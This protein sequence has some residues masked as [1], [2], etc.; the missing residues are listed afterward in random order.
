[1]S[2]DH[3][4]GLKV[5][6][7]LRHTLK[8]ACCGNACRHCVWE[9][10]A[11]SREVR[12]RRRFNSAF[13]VDKKDLLVVEETVEREAVKEEVSEEGPKAAPELPTTCC[14]SGCANCVWL[15]YGQELVE[16]YQA[17]GEVVGLDQLLEVV[18][19][20]V[21]DP[22]VRAFVVMELKAKFRKL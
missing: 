7:R 17:R 5:I 3:F 12:D 2:S 11:V 13:W 6:T 15:D 22:M 19:G 4:P 16:Y 1:M 21:Q 14:E 10:E 18:R 20:S 9:H 8:G